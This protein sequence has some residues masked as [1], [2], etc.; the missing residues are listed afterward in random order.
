MAD[1]NSMFCS[2]L[3]REVKKEL[4]A[5]GIKVPSLSTVRHKSGNS[6]QFEVWRRDIGSCG[7]FTAYNASEAK[8]KYLATLLPKEE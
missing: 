3:L 5:A 7:W 2:V 1:I 6:V 4:K 8:Y